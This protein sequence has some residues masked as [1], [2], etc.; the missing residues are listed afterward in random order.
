MK[1]NNL[2]LR[3]KRVYLRRPR[4]SD[5]KEF[6]EMARKSERFHRGLMNPAKTRE[7]F[8]RFLGRVDNDQTE[9]FLICQS[10]DNAIAGIINLS[11]IFYGSFQNAYLGY[12]LGFDF[13]GQG[14]ATEAVKIILKYAFVELKLHRVEANVQP[15]NLASIRVL[16]KSG[17]KKEGFSE[18]YLKISGRWRDHERWA[19]IRENYFDG[20]R[21]GKGKK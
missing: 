10:K 14:Y 12:G 6:T 8:K 5:E 4:L 11:Q 17:F 9:S 16:E 7:E 21:H 15:H 2:I 1:N 18:K 19:I 13:A 20:S 3:G